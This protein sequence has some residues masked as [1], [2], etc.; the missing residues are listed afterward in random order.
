MDFRS[1]IR[2]ITKGD[3]VGHDF[4]GNQWTT[5]GG[6]SRRVYWHGSPNGQAG[7]KVAHYGIHVGGYK[8]AKEA[9]EARIGRRADGKD[10]NGDQEYGKT[11]IMGSDGQPKLPQTAYYE[12]PVKGSFGWETDGNKYTWEQVQQMRSQDPKWVANARGAVY[13]DGSPVPMDSKPDLFPVA[14]TGQMKNTPNTPISDDRANSTMTRT[15]SA[16]NAKNGYY[17]SNEGEGVTVD[18]NGKI[19]NDISAVVPSPA[20]LTAIPKEQVVAK[21]DVVGHVFHGNQWLTTGGGFNPNPNGARR[22]PA[23]AQPA[24]APRVRQPKPQPAPKAPTSAKPDDKS[25]QNGKNFKGLGSAKIASKGSELFL[26]GNQQ[27]FMG[28]VTMENGE[29]AVVKQIGDWRGISG[30]EM[31]KAEVLASKV[32]EA[33]DFPIRGVAPVEG[34]DDT[35]VQAWVEGKSF[36][37][38]GGAFNPAKEISSAPVELRP[39]LEE[40]KFFDALTGNPDRHYG[41]LMISGIPDTVTSVEEAGKVAGASIVGIDHSLAFL[42]TRN[43]PPFSSD[44]QN[45]SARLDEGRVTAIGEGLDNLL[46]GGTLT[47][48]EQPYVEAMVKQMNKAFPQP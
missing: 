42:N 44:L 45:A 43:F 16:G 36:K 29:P 28:K 33:C 37:E 21:G 46:K 30:E 12:H 48:W 27:K 24:K 47:S 5:V 39:Q 31:A 10:W 14:I 2:N 3:V 15:I 23:E 13:S 18:A 40:I 7:M 8:A 34:A 17:Y 35:V 41:N 4:H 38:L 22:K 1:I 9:L 25:Q 20:H 26:G 19:V 11:L 6:V 32:G